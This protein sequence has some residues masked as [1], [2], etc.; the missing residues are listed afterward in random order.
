MLIST[1]SRQS[2]PERYAG[3]SGWRVRVAVIG[4]DDEL[5]SGARGGRRDLVGAAQAVGSVGVDVEDAGDRAVGGAAATASA[6]RRE[7]DADQNSN[8]GHEGRRREQQLLH[9]P[10]LT[11]DWRRLRL[12]AAAP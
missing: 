12:P 6:A 1:P 2:T 9:Q 3:G 4:E 5:Q 8:G 11:D 10:T 7:R